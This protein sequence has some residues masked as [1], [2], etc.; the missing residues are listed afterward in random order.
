MHT[1]VI[2]TKTHPI[3]CNLILEN[4]NCTLAV[5]KRILCEWSNQDAYFLTVVNLIFLNKNLS[6]NWIATLCLELNLNAAFACRWPRLIV[7]DCPWDLDHLWIQQV[8]PRLSAVSE[9]TQLNAHDALG[10]SHYRIGKV[11]DCTAFYRKDTSESFRLRFSQIILV[12]DEGAR[13][14]L[15]LIAIFTR[16]HAVANLHKG[17]VLYYKHSNYFFLC[18]F[19]FK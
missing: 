3:I 17:I 14:C 18:G 5:N 10:A 6:L 11:F 2:D 4:F 12:D 13:F 7:E 15:F 9:V 16:D 19:L 1:N 8:Y